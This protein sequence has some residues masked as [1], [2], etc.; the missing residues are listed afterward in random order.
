M[1]NYYIS[2]ATPVII[3]IAL[4]FAVAQ[5]IDVLYTF[6]YQVSLGLMD[7]RNKFFKQVTTIYV[8]LTRS[9]S[10]KYQILLLRKLLRCLNGNLSIKWT[11]WLYLRLFY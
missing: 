9:L 7:L 11:L 1:L 5:V 8:I 2:I 10:K 3:Y 6:A 4:F